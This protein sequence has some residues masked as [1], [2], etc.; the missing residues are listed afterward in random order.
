MRPVGR[1][2]DWLQESYRREPALIAALLA[3]VLGL[4]IVSIA[5][6][7]VV[8][9]RRPRAPRPAESSWR[10]ALKAAEAGTRVS[11]SIARSTASGPAAPSTGRTAKASPEPIRW[12][13]V[14]SFE[15][16]DGSATALPLQGTMVRIGRHEENDIRLASKTV[17]RYHAVVHVTPE[18]DYVL[19]DL[20][21]S[22]GNGI[23][24]NGARVEQAQLRPGD[25]VEV[26]EVRLRFQ[27]AARH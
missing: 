4:P 26:G 14:A 7:L 21:G 15:M 1:L 9:L 12:S 2:I 19:T 16:L 22:G 18:R 25:V 10:D 13:S 17:H 6:L 27:L 23:I 11:T 24:V 5:A 8:T 3:L 20:S